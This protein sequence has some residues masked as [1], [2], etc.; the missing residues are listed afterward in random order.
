[1]VEPL[2]KTLLKLLRKS[3][4]EVPYGRVISLLGMY[5]QETQSLSPRVL[6]APMFLAVLLIIAKDKAVT[7]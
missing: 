4:T 2:L 1:M 6:C 3:K 7:C 5:L